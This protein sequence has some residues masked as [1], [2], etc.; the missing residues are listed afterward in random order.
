[1]AAVPARRRK[2]GL[3]FRNRPGAGPCEAGFSGALLEPKE[4]GPGGGVAE[5]TAKRPSRLCRALSQGSGWPLPNFETAGGMGRVIVAI[6]RF[7]GLCSIP[8]SAGSRR[9]KRT[10]TPAGS[11]PP[12]TKSTRSFGSKIPANGRPGRAPL[13]GPAQPSGPAQQGRGARPRAPTPPAHG[14]PSRCVAPGGGAAR[15]ERA[16]LPPPAPPRTGWRPGW[17]PTFAWGFFRR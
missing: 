15:R 5:E 17:R 4:S 2:S 6:F 16:P 3:K 1:M 10:V 8:V 14:W 11:I 12:P 9:G 7:S 13:F